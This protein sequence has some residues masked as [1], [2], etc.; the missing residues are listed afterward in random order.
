MRDNQLRSSHLETLGHVDFD[1]LLLS[2]LEHLLEHDV[3]DGLDLHLG[4][5]P[6]DNDL[7]LHRRHR[8]KYSAPKRVHTVT[9]R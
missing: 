8:A 7:I 9:T 2:P 3:R 4:Q 5:L 6:E 1:A